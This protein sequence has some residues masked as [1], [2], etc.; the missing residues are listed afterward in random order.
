MVLLQNLMRRA[1][2][3]DLS[4]LVDVLVQAMGSLSKAH[5]SAYIKHAGYS[6]QLS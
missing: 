2:A 3:R 4:T 1:A 5:A 6:A